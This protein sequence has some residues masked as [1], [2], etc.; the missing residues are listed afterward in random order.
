MIT[1]VIFDSLK[2]SHLGMT[3]FY[4]FAAFFLISFYSKRFEVKDV[5]G[6]IMLLFLVSVLYSH[7]FDYKF[8]LFMYLVVL[9]IIGVVLLIL[10][11]KKNISYD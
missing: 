9:A 1:A 2:L 4:L 6:F 3:A 8:N 7:F 10:K 11:A 5:A